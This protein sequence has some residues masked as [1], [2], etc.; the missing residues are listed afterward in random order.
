MRVRPM[1]KRKQLVLLLAVVIVCSALTV[2]VPTLVRAFAGP[3]ED[4]IHLLDVLSRIK[5]DY[6]EEVPTDKLIEGA[7]R[8]M[9]ESLED[10]Y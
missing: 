1:R 7:L 10:P 8:G 3:D 4:V 6:V 5:E 2:K 9:V